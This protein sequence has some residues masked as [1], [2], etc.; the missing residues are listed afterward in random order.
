MCYY[1]IIFENIII[2]WNSKFLKAKNNTKRKLT[3]FLETWLHTDPSIKSLDNIFTDNETKSN[4]LSIH[5]SSILKSAKQLKQ[6]DSI[7]SFNANSWINY[8][9]HYFISILN[10]LK[11]LFYSMFFLK[12]AKLAFFRV[13]ITVIFTCRWKVEVFGNGFRLLLFDLWIINIFIIIASYKFTNN[14]NGATFFCEF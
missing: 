3:S 4:T 7:L 5:L 9:N 2:I 1:F 6:F 14:F 13:G 12:F 8:R 11:N 10:R